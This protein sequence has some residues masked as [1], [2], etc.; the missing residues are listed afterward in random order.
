MALY[1]EVI[2]LE[3]VLQAVHSIREADLKTHDELKG[4]G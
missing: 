4:I 1:Y 2:T 3:K